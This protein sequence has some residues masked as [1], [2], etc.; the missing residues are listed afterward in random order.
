MDKIKPKPCPFCG[1]DDIT[2]WRNILL[3]M[4]GGRCNYCGADSGNKGYGQT[5]QEAAAAWNKRVPE[6]EDKP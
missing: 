5:K 2:L 3:Q 4:V 6:K 1:C